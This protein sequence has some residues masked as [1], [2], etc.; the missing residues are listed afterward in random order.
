MRTTK[1]TQSLSSAS[2]IPVHPAV[3]T[4]LILP[5]G[6]LTG[7]VSVTLAYLFSKEGISV[8]KVAAMVAASLLPHIFKF[9]WAPLVDSMF[10]LKKWY[11]IANMV[12]AFGIL[13]TGVLPIQESSL[14]LLTFILILSNFMIT[15]LCMA[16]E[17]LMA[18]DVPEELKGRAGGFWQAGNLG[19]AGLGGGAGLWLAQRLPEEWM[20]ASILAVTCLCCCTGLFFLDE[21]KS[22]I[23]EH[24]LSKTYR[25]LFKDVWSTLKT[26][27]GILALFLS[28][29]TLGSGAAQSLWSAIAKDWGAGADTVAL[30]T[31]VMGGLFSVAGCLFGGW[32]CD[33]IKRQTAYLL[34]G[35]IGA[36]CALG[37]AYSPKS[38][39][40]YIIWTSL[41]AVIMGMSYAGLSAFILE[42]IGK[43]A[44]VT[45]FNIYA[46]LSNAPI[47]LMIYIEGWAHSRWGAKGMLNT[48]AAFAVLAIV[49]FLLLKTLMIERKRFWFNIFPSPRPKPG[50]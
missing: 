22:T 13:A 20:V 3:F 44:A 40:M 2:H 26:K 5:L 9:L 10:S 46:A 21:P 6:I 24:R 32:I 28:F 47:Y 42:A 1:N 43:G 17:G 25:N 37:M 39:I 4:L 7:Y 29:L 50:I 16:T 49:L 45:K 11:L 12:S 48:E 36:L 34:F 8:E 41:Y 14:V 19:G 18:Y 15:F 35:L 38:E 27:M 23:R 30:V 31:G 33:R